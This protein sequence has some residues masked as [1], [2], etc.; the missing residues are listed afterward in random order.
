[1][2]VVF[3][4]RF[5]QGDL[6]LRLK[7]GEVTFELCESMDGENTHM[8]VLSEESTE[9]FEIVGEAKP[10]W[11]KNVDPGAFSRIII[12]GTCHLEKKMITVYLNGNR[13]AQVRPKIPIH[14]TA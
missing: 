10:L 4:V 13:V 2:N 6:R 9:I 7:F 1:M 11:T 5:V 14:L 8:L 12:V 3:D